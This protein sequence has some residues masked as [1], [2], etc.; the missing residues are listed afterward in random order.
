MAKVLTKVEDIAKLE[1]G[2]I[3]ETKKREKIE[4]LT[5]AREEAGEAYHQAQ[6]VYHQARKAHRQTE[7]VYL[8]AC[9]ALYQITR[10]HKGGAK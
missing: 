7:E 10:G 8:Q 9:E 1:Q 3:L 5:Q 4:R 2:E 6:E